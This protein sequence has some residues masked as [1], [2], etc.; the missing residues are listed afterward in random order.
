M[1]AAARTW[2]RALAVTKKSHLLS[3]IGKGLDNPIIPRDYRRQA[4]N[5][6]NSHLTL[7]VSLV[8]L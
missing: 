2:E 6:A 3:L 5:R 8:R 1:T 7:G 4:R